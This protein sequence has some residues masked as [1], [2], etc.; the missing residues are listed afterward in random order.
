ML[1][2][3]NSFILLALLFLTSNPICVTST[4]TDLNTTRKIFIG[5][6]KPCPYNPKTTVTILN[7]LAIDE[8]LTLHCKS[9]DD[10]LGTHVIQY[11]QEY[12]FKFRPNLFGSTL[13]FCGMSWSGGSKVFDVYK[14]IRDKRRCCGDV[15]WDVQ[16]SGMS[17]PSTFSEQPPLLYTWN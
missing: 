8:Q 13:Y 4:K 6:K 17:S 1:N 14:F 3:T 11:G 16:K 10:D 5:D 9:G 15:H 2:F 12:Q 7:Q